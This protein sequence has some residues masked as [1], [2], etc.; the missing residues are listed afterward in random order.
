LGGWK[1]K[2][3]SS[4]SNAV[5]CGEQKK[6]KRRRASEDASV[7]EG[8][9]KGLPGFETW[10]MKRKKGPPGL[11]EKPACGRVGSREVRACRLD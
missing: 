10:G 9:I 3:G 4:E 8:V 1:K 5:K 2:G 7:G 6:I 11:Q